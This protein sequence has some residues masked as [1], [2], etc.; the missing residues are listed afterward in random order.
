[1]TLVQ[2]ITPAATPLPHLARLDLRPLL[3]GP[4]NRTTPGDFEQAGAL[5]VVEVSVD[6]DLAGEPVGR[7]LVFDFLMRDLDPDMRRFPA[8]LGGVK[9]Q[10]HGGAGGKRRAQQIIGGRTCAE[11]D[12][13][14]R[15]VGQKLRAAHRN[16]EL[17]L[18]GTRGLYDGPG[19]RRA[20]F[21]DLFHRLFYLSLN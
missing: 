15:L 6:R 11:A 9:A 20:M 8:L 1:M 17:Y 18:A 5:G 3:Q 21:T 19:A 4:V 13:L 2:I 14:D 10:G 12:S 16:I 7:G